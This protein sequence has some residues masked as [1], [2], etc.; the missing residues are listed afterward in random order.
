MTNPRSA[1][2]D[3]CAQDY[4]AGFGNEFSSEAELGALPIGQNSPQRPPLGLYAEQLSGT[5][6][7]VPRSE[8]R[9]S[10][11]YRI[12]PSAVHSRYVPFQCEDAWS[13]LNDQRIP[14]PNRLRWDPFP[15]PSKPTDF[16]DGVHTIAV[17]GDPR[18]QTGA[19]AHIY[20]VNRSMTT[21]V[22]FDSDGE[23]M[24]VPYD[25]R[26]HLNTEFG[27]IELSPG[28]IGVVPRGVRFRVELIDDVARGYLCENFGSAFR[29][30]QLGPIGSNGLANS[31]DF[32]TPVA[33]YEDADKPFEL[34]QRFM[35]NLWHT[36]LPHSPLDV[37]AWYGSL[38]PYKYDL[39]RFNTIGTVSFDH[40]DPSIFTVLT[41]PSETL[42]TA[43][44]DFVIFPPR[45][46]VAEHTFRPPWYHRNVMSELMG[47]IKGVYD[48]KAEGFAPGGI[49]LH[50]CMS[51][52]G[53]DAATHT[54]ATKEQLAP[55]KIDETMAF[56]FEC[57]WVFQPTSWAMKSP[58]LQEG[59]DACWTGLEKTFR[60]P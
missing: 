24:F 54:K 18:M 51:A 27:L 40:P 11:L 13:G 5:A 20:C 15:P 17:S 12:H 3:Q 55:N 30:P 48:A 22:F 43:N 35:G 23:L 7:T 41:S 9:R 28:E 29:L 21:R 49:S 26:I 4:M 60:R 38:A 56:M 39:S 10:W 42:G 53:P 52:H 47:L 6:F 46:M 57:R 1:G 58:A 33:R 34:F 44:I 31:R 32:L 36:E 59:Y 2:T 37:V 16:V 50:N 14:T 45:W 8:N 25:G 19:A